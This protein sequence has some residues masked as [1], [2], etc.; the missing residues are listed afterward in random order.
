MSLME[1]NVYKLDPLT[2][3]RWPEF[4]ARHPESSIFHSPGWLQALRDTYGYE[5]VVLTTSQ[6]GQLSNGIVFCQVRSWLTGNRLVSVPF[7]DHCQP[8]AGGKDLQDIVRF[9]HANRRAQ[10]WK[11]IEVR[12]RA[13]EDIFQNEPDFEMS[14]SYAFHV[15]DLKPPLE[16]I[17]RGFHESCVR[18]KI[19]RADKEKLTF[20]SGNSEALLEKFNRLLL[21]TRRRHKLPPQPA[22]WFRNLAHCL[23]EQLTIHLL[24]KDADPIASIITLSHK[25]S[26]VY[27]Y[28]VSDARFHNL[29][30]MSLLFWKV[31][32]MGK[33]AGALE[34]DLGRSAPD[35]PGLAAFKE[36]LGGVVSQLKYYRNP[37]PSAPKPMS[38]TKTPWAREALARLPDPVLVGAGRFLYRHLG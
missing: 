6:G 21:L 17:Y 11:Y 16:T 28:G 1:T 14:Q 34:L 10:G 24:S 3:P 33:Q 4:L 19:K 35:D 38:S 2:D 22:A 13:N 15:I 29:G 7:S 23:G 31:I 20:E 12:P 26:L 30:G 9:A 5:P 37:A 8:L 32:Q 25:N 36:H 27:K 18:R